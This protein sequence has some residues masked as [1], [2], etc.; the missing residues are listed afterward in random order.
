MLLLNYFAQNSKSENC[1]SSISFYEINNLS[2]KIARDCNNGIIVKI[3]FDDISSAVSNWENV[4]QIV[5]YSVVLK[6]KENPIFDKIN[7][8]NL[9]MPN[10]VKESCLKIFSQ[11]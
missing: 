2:S 5:D 8:L 6:D 7:I 3:N 11:K 4:F 9:M 1:V 10:F